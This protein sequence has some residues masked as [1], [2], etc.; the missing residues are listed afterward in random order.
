MTIR[1]LQIPTWAAFLAL[2]FATS[3]SLLA[4]G[5]RVQAPRQPPEPFAV[6][7]HPS[8]P[9]DPD[10]REGLEEATREVRA[11]VRRR[12]DWFRLAEAAED[13]DIILRI[14]NY[15]MAETMMPK[16]E[17]LIIN[18]QVQLVERSEIVEFHYVDAVALAGDARE[19][20]TGLDER[21][22]GSSLRNAASH[23]AEELER[24]CKE[25]YGAL[26][27]PQ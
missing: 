21:Q 14:I 15:R 3:S 22:N 27:S 8:E 5:E 16:L 6:F 20:L 4:A 7:V 25:N 26:T 9:E 17:R 18:G 23:L 1:P 11:R 10:L 13:A 24:F 12:G 2:V 19:S